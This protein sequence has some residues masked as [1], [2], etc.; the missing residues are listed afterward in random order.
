MTEEQFDVLDCA[1]RKTGAVIGRD[2]A[3]AS[4]AWHGAFHC[5][6][7]YRR[8]GRELALFQKRSGTKRIAPGKFDVSVG[9]H[10]AAGE[11]AV[12]AGPREIGEELGLAVPFPAL[13]PV[14]RRVFVYCYTAGTVEH[15]IQ[16]VFLL[17]RSLVPGDLSLQKEELDGIIE[18]DVEQGI[19]LFAGKMPAI[20][21]SLV[22]PSGAQD[23]ILVAAD[24]F[25]PCLDNYYL[26]LL[27][28]ARRYM[29]G[30]RDLLII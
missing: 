10:Y 21:L 4:G 15:E 3:H 26:K 12:T 17:P 20:P 16:D 9:G 13:V 7:I 25:V 11:D 2:V 19:A 5:L 30:E 22:R 23:R 27:V 18:M 14:G 1:G 6:I 8:Q 24:D 28:L 29:A